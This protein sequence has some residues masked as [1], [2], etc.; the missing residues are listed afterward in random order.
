MAMRGVGIGRLA[1]RRAQ[2]LLEDQHI[3]DLKAA[4]VPVRVA[5]VAP[6]GRQHPEP[7]V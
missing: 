5:R 3:A 1:G 6:F 4:D 2:N 7:Q